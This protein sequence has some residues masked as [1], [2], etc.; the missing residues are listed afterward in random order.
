MFFFCFCFLSTL[1]ARRIV[2]KTYFYSGLLYLR[3]K[4]IA[5]FVTLN[6]FQLEIHNNNNNIVILR[7]IREIF[8]NYIHYTARTRATILCTTWKR[9]Y[10]QMNF[11]VSRCVRN[12][13]FEQIFKFIHG[14]IWMNNISH[15]LRG[16]SSIIHYSTFFFFLRFPVKA[17]LLNRKKSN[18]T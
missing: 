6:P 5:Q 10:K 12:E 2:W 16:S 8:N 4:D 14:Q 18:D 9:P 1:N 15:F 13:I 17:Q 3:A 7:D 11:D